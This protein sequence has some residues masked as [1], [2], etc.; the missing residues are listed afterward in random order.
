[1]PVT[2]ITIGSGITMSGGFTIN[3]QFL[4][5]MIVAINTSPYIAAWQWSSASGFGTRYANPG[6]LPAD[7]VVGIVFS[8]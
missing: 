2:G 8:P 5:A 7:D 1:M 3:S 4:E 6:T